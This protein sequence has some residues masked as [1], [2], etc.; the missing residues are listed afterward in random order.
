MFDFHSFHGLASF[1]RKFIQ[2]FSSIMC[3]IK[4]FLKGV[5][6]KWSK[7]AQRTFEQIK[8]MMTTA[9]V[10]VLS[11]FEQLSIMEYDASHEGI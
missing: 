4:K 7:S 6:F 2:N 10:L 8:E 5:N 1:Y 11:D 9:P 3:R